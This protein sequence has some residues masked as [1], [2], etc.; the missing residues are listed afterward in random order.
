MTTLIDEVTSFAVFKV[1][2]E[3]RGSVSINLSVAFLNSAA[4]NRDILILASCD[5]LSKHLAFTTA[6]VY[7]EGSLK[8]LAT[9]EHTKFMMNRP[10]LNSPKL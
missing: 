3:L 10:I 4:V 1:D 2:K 8:L 5:K 6:K 7:D 9:G